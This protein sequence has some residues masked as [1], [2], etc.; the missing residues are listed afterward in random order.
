MLG[1]SGIGFICSLGFTVDVLNEVA[2]PGALKF[3]GS[4]QGGGTTPYDVTVWS[5]LC[6]KESVP[7]KV[8]VQ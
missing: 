4:L 2:R 3:S 8:T 6:S 7:L 5:L 1:R